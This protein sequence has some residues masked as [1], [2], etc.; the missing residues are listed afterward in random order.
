MA[1]AWIGNREASL[2]DAAGEAAKLLQSSRCP[3]FSFDTDVH[4]TRA[5]IA[6]AERIG[7]AYD[8]VDGAALAHETALLTDRGSTTVAPGEA[9]RRADVV[10]IVGELP[11]AHRRLLL[12]FAVTGPDLPAAA[13][14]AFFSVGNIAPA[15]DG[16]RKVTPLT[17]EGHGLAATLAGLRAQCA[18]RQVTAPVKNFDRFAAALAKARYPVFLYSGHSADA[19]A[20]EMLQGLISDLNASGRAAGLLL[21]ASESGWG[22]ALASGWMT[23]FPPRTG[24]SRG[25]PEFDPWRFDVARMIADGEADCHLWISGDPERPPPKARNGLPLIV[26]ARTDGPAAGA[27][28]TVGI[29]QAGLDHDGVVYSAQVGTLIAAVART[30]SERSAAAD[31][32][33]AIATAIPAGAVLPC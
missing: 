9:R 11:E 21:P 20:L 2:Q 30:R 18:G 23:G 4:G 28:V 16:K 19:L 7:A 5:A 1:V 14:R 33:R 29:G 12:E 6:L 3:V 8:H 15:L 31:I 27:A 22:A 17:C 10:V 25:F 13:E 32:L 24:F 26:C